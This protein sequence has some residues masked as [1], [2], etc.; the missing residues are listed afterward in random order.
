MRRQA[1]SELIAETTKE[2]DFDIQTMNA[3][4][5]GPVDWIGSAGTAPFLSSKRTVVVRNLL[6]KGPPEEAFGS[7]KPKFSLPEY[8]LLILV[9]DEETGDESRQRRLL[10][11]RKAWE[12]LVTASGGM[13]V[14]FDPDPKTIKPAIRIKATAQGKALSSQAL[15]ALVEMTGN[16]LSRAL[17]ELEKLVVYAGEQAQI[18]EADVRAVVVPS[19]DW[20]IFKLVDAVVAGNVG[21]GLRQLRL[22]VGTSTKAEAAAF[23]SI[24]PQLSKQLRLAWQARCCIDAGIGPAN[25][26][27]HI[28][29]MFPD[30]PNLA[31]EADWSQR[32]AMGIGQRLDH[33]QISRCFQLL[34]DANARLVGL[35]PGFSAIETLERMV[36]EMAEVVRAKAAIR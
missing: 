13:T 2:D 35:L 21:E 10:G 26:P 14:Q 31:K 19:R 5:S 24:F 25:P 23:Q 6:R 20:Y 9:V 15:D 16:S 7:D 28:L 3:D 27:E 33:D 30:R 17:E 29:A 32:R 11:Y 22:L 34:S 4:E 8:A 12:K 1:L 18:S 36:L